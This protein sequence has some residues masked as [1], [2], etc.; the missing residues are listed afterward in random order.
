MKFSIA[1]AIFLLIVVPILSIERALS[2][3]SLEIRAITR[4]VIVL[5][6]PGLIILA[7]LVHLLRDVL[8]LVLHH[9]TIL[10]TLLDDLIIGEKVIAGAF[11][12]VAIS[13]LLDRPGDASVETD[14][15]LAALTVDVMEE[16]PFHLI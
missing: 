3:I 12:Q 2:T 9:L 10:P 11:V 6:R 5:Y 1:C 8:R 7:V 14:R 16:E 13:H 4:P 15:G